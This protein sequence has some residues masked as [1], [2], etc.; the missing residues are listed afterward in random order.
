MN[1]YTTFENILFNFANQIGSE[2]N[3]EKV[4]G[5]VKKVEDE[6]QLGEN[7]RRL[8]EHFTRD[9]VGIN[10]F[11]NFHRHT[12]SSTSYIASGVI[13]GLSTSY[14]LNTENN[15]TALSS[16]SIGAAS[17]MILEYLLHPFRTFLYSFV[18]NIRAHKNG[19]IVSSLA[20]NSSRMLEA[21]DNV[22]SE[23]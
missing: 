7:E 8:L 9:V 3:P 20:R 10:E 5:L 23:A 1:K 4:E 11:D 21:I 22:D 15:L 16:F 13:V 17:G 12:E 6:K 14:L 2:T 18:E 19:K